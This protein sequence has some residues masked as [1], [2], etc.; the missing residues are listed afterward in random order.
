MSIKKLQ[1][2]LSLIKECISEYEGEEDTDEGEDEA[3]AA[4]AD[5][6]GY[7]ESSGSSSGKNKAVIMALKKRM[8][9]QG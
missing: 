9:A 3:P 7:E 8:G 2:A 5:D 4:E 6:A 1:Q